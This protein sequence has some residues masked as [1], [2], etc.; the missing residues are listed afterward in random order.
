MNKIKPVKSKKVTI[1][2]VAQDAGVSVAAVS[3]V[4]RNAYGVSDNLRK[5]V[6]A[7]IDR[8]GYRPSTAARGMRGKTFTIGLLVVNIDNPFL[9]EVIDAVNDV[10]A[11][12]EY[13]T[14]IGVGRARISMETA[15]IESMIDHHMDG[16]ILI[17]PRMAEEILEQFARQIP[18]VVIG[19]HE[20]DGSAFDTVN[21]DD[22]TGAKMAVQ[23]LIDAG[24]RRIDM[25]S[26]KIRENTGPNVFNVREE[27][28]REA[29][30]EA[31]LAEY[32][33]IYGGR[34]EQEYGTEDARRYLDENKGATAVF[35]WSDLHGVP[36]LNV[37]MERGIRVPDDLAIIGFD[38][39]PV[40]RL[41]IV[42]L[43]SISQNAKQLG[44]TAAQ[45]LLERMNGKKEASHILI[46]PRLITPQKLTSA[47]L[48]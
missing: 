24:H 32:I 1:K 33:N 23:S 17:A 47:C 46:E 2:T 9:P 36:L 4:L 43:S 38:D 25:L 48:V 34:D 30:T 11:D 5:T 41:P 40:V 6:Q 7:S 21:A 16:L 18:I 37:A 28:Y 19:H 15:M 39:S 14:M 42:G 12:A 20:A 31:G 45:I 8:L 44:A 22:F 3:K 26:L 35:C 13:Q 29:M 10:L 27:G